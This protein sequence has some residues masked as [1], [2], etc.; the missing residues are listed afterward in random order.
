[1]SNKKHTLPK[2]FRPA[3]TCWDCRSCKV[4]FDEDGQGQGRYR[5]NHWKVILS[6]YTAENYICDEFKQR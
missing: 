4:V 1:M 2:H 3:S 5:C 6:D